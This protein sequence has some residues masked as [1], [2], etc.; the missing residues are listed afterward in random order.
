M[1]LDDLR[2]SWEQHDRRLDEALR[3]NRRLLV[4]MDLDKTKSMMQR[5]RTL[6]GMELVVDVLAVV[7][8]GSFIGSHLAEPRFLVPAFI[9]N[10]AA[11]GIFIVELVQWMRAG[12]IN[13]DA[14]VLEIQR[15]L[16]SL[17]VLR[18]RT[19]QGVLLLAP[20]LWTPL[21][22]VGM[23]A[24]LNLDAYEVLGTRYLIANLVFGLVFMAAVLWAC[25]RFADRLHRSS[26]VRSLAR[27]VA[28][29]SLT[30]A[31]D[32][33]ARISAFEREERSA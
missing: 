11:V 9:L 13:Y 6:L 8:L 7:A 2:R 17:R 15:R 30:S 1:E 32:Q 27:D 19:T 20:L 12:A 4:S 10:V 18:I 24:G 31:M 5:L 3:L 29:K 21:L 22:I 26:L 23:R 28:G 33:L 25:R 14:P 16:E